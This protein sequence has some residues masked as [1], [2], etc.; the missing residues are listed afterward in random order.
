MS[1]M[2][3]TDIIRHII[4]LNKYILLCYIVLKSILKEGN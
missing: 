1:F 4:I 3:D 2:G